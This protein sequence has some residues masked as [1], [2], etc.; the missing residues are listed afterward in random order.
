MKNQFNLLAL[1]CF[2]SIS[3]IISCKKEAEPLPDTS[4]EITVA[5]DLGNKVNGATVALFNNHEDWLKGSNQ[6]ATE[7]ITDAN[8]VAVFSNLTSKQYY[9]GVIKDC[10]SNIHGSITTDFAISSYKNNKVS[11]VIRGTG[12]IQLINNS[13]N[14][15]SIYI[16]G[17]ITANMEGGTTT[18]LSFRPTGSYSVRVLQLSGYLFTPTDLTYNGNVSCGGTLLTAFPN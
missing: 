8:G 6:V 17:A 11:T 13:S 3:S 18:T 4:L 2:A 9:W 14:P 10:K 16:N 1:L 12:T 15:Y 5:D 7:K